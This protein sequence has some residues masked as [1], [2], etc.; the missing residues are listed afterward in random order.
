[1]EILLAGAQAHSLRQILLHPQAAQQRPQYAAALI[2]QLL[3]AETVLGVVDVAGILKAV[4]R[5]APQRAAAIVPAHAPHL[6]IVSGGP[7]L[8]V[9]L[10]HHAVVFRREASLTFQHGVEILRLQKP[11]MPPRLLI[12]L[13]QR[14]RRQVIFVQLP[15]KAVA[16][17]AVEVD[18]ERQQQRQQRAVFPGIVLEI[19]HHGQRRA[20][21]LVERM[22]LQCHQAAGGLHLSEE[23]HGEQDELH[24]ADERIA[25][26]KPHC[27]GLAVL[28]QLQK[29]LLPV[30]L[31]ALGVQR[32]VRR[33]GVQVDIQI[34]L[35]V[36]LR[37][38]TE[39]PLALS[40]LVVHKPYS[41]RRVPRTTIIPPFPPLS[42]KNAG[43][44]WAFGGIQWH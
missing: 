1:M 26:E 27:A 37:Q 33:I 19:P 6:H 16:H 12:R 35:D 30:V 25:L 22:H 13:R 17:P 34:G 40:C 20:L 23:I 38:R 41:F 28:P 32:L 31:P 36:A 5:V 7:H 10:L 4:R 44:G 21:F 42:N 18:A 8:L 3:Y 29:V 15:G 11:Q 24:G 39:R 9:E 14:R 43:A 2:D